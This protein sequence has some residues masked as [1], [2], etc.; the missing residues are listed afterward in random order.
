MKLALALIICS[1]VQVTCMPPMHT[2]LKFD[3]WNDCMIAG[4]KEAIDFIE[5]ADSNRIN[6]SGLYLKFV[7][8]ETIEEEKI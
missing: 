1:A 7:C 6:D 8:Y 4:H 3:N 2:G 5:K